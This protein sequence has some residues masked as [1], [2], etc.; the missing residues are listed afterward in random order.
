[1]YNLNMKN[2]INQLFYD[3]SRQVATS[4][5]SF[6]TVNPATNQI[7]TDVDMASL[8]DVEKAIKSA[9]EG[10]TVWSKFSGTERGRILKKAADLLRERNE[11]LARIEVTD[12]GKPISEAITVDVITGATV[13]S[14][15]IIHAAAKALVE[16]ME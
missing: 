9:K 13:T 8:Q 1:M 6:S 7:I 5:H 3:G 4:G 15:A 12:T 14:D 16:A 11:E 10:F 2:K